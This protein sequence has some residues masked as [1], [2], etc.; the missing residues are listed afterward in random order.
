MWS[1]SLAREIVN[2]LAVKPE[3]SSAVVTENW[4][5]EIALGIADMLRAYVTG[6][7]LPLADTTPMTNALNDLQAAIVAVQNPVP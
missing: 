1:D 3:L 6:D 2:L 7:V 4:W 5:D